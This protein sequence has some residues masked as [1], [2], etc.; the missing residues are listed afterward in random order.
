M[1][2]DVVMAIDEEAAGENKRGSDQTEA[3][4]DGAQRTS[5]GQGVGLRAQRVSGKS[6]TR[7]GGGGRVR[8]EKEF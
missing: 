3:I 6:R 4:G 5:G 1:D 8:E 2:V 7:G